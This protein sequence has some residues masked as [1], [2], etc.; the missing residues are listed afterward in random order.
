MKK[1]YIKNAVTGTYINEFRWSFYWVSD[2]SEVD[3][4]YTDISDAEKV[5]SNFFLEDFDDDYYII[6]IIYSRL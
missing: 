2:I 5:L 4:F 6:E 3:K 1:Y